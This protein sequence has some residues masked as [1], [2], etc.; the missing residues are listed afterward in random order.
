MKKIIANLDYI[1]GHLR[2]GHIELELSNE[3]YEEFNNS[4][5][6]EKEEWIKECGTPVVDD[7]E[8]D[9]CGSI[10]EIKVEDA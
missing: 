7:Y 5:E 1:Q 2:Y 6:E 8:I 4:S 9:S 10:T 3:K